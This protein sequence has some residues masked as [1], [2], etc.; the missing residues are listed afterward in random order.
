VYAIS[1]GYEDGNDHSELRHDPALQSAV[2]KLRDLASGPT[3]C[4]FKNT[5]TKETAW[6]MHEILVETFI[7][8]FEKAPDELILD[9][10]ATDIPVHGAQEGKFFHG[11]TM[12]ITA[13]CRCMCSAVTSFWLRICDRARSMRLNMRGR[14]WR[15]W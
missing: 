15:C 2:G 10:D 6:Q 12:T 9:V 4:R 13:F 14:S 3:I 1:Q 7:A 5:A 11:F 8:P